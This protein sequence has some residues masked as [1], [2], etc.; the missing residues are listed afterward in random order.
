MLFVGPDPL[1]VTVCLG[2]ECRL[3]VSLRTLRHPRILHCDRPQSLLRRVKIP[4][5]LL[6]VVFGHFADVDG[7]TLGNRLHSHFLSLHLL[8]V[9]SLE[10]LML[11]LA[12]NLFES[13]LHGFPLHLLLPLPLLLLPALFCLLLAALHVRI[14]LLLELHSVLEGVHMVGFLFFLSQCFVDLVERQEELIV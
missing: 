8:L 13:G 2:L 3:A 14:T 11:S 6:L 4:V 10:L 9:L 1:R 5:L 12:C 7:L